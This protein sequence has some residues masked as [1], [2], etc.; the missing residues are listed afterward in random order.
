MTIVLKVANCLLVVR[1]PY[2]HA[3]KDGINGLVHDNKPIVVYN[4]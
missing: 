3:E 1:L 2:R 4:D